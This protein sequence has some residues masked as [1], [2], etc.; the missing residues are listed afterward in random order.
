MFFH[1]GSLLS[2][3]FPDNRPGDGVHFPITEEME[4][5]LREEEEVEE[6]GQQGGTGEKN[7]PASVPDVLS[8]T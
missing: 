4:R 1:Y 2:L 6:Q 3:G 7:A 5:L 8:Q